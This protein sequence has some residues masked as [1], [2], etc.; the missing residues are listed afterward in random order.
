MI[1]QFSKALGNPPEPITALT[2]AAWY[3]YGLG[4]T[5]AGGGAVSAWAD[6]SGNA[7]NAA[8]GTGANRPTLN[9]DNSITFDSSSVAKSLA[10][11]FTFNQPLTIYALI[12]TD[13]W[14][15]GKR[16]IDGAAAAGGAA[17]LTSTPQIG[18][19]AG[20]QVGNVSLPLATYGIIAYVLN[21]ASS[22]ISLNNGT[23]IT[24]NSG[25]NNPGGIVIGNSASGATTGMGV[26]FK[27]LIA[28]SSAHDA[29]N[30]T[31]VV[32]YLATVG[33]INL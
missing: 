25:A 32:T 12:R 13:T 16:F 21:G 8:Q 17:Y 14:G 28:F 26:T 4:I 15:S 24:G 11:A 22:L 19:N 9:A 29:T 3:R 27:E 1:P 10:V 23:P 18:I 30:I 31:K 2:P 7:R 5:D 6:Q 20:G 33:G